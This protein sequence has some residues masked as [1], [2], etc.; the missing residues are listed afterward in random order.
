VTLAAGTRIGSYEILGP[1]GAGG[2]GEVY[3]AIDSELH[4]TVALKVLPEH[5]ITDPDRVA[6]FEREA[7]TLASINHPHVAQ[8]YGIAR[9]DNERAV[10]VMEFVEGEDLAARLRRGRLPLDEALAIG[11]QVA[12]ALEATHEIGVIHRD[13]KPGN[14]RVR[15]DGVVKVLDFGLA[16]TAD[17]RSPSGDVDAPTIS[18]TITEPGFTFGT[19]AYMS[20]EQAKGSTVD[21]RSDLWSFGCVL[22]EMLSGRRA[23]NAT[24][25]V[26]TVAAVLSHGP[27]WDQLP[28]DTSQPIRR[29]LR[30][31]LVRERAQRIDSAAVARLAIE[32]VLSKPGADP[33]PTTPARRGPNMWVVGGLALVTV[34]ILATIAWLPRAPTV[35]SELRLDIATP[36][37]ADAY[38]F[39][40]SPDGRRIAFVSGGSGNPLQLWT[41]TFDSAAATPVPN[42]E[43]A[44]YTFWS[45]DGR[46]IGFFAG[47]KLKRVELSSGIAV[48]LADAAAG[49]GGSW[50]ANGQ[51]LFT[52]SASAPIYLVSA[53]GSAVRPVTSLAPG[54]GGHVSPAWHPDGRRFLYLMRNGDPDKRGSY[55]ATLDRPE[56]A[57]LVDAEGTS[58]FRG[59][60]EILY[61]RDGTLYVQAFDDANNVMTGAARPVASPVPTSDRRSAY[62]ASSSG[63]MAYRKGRM[64]GAQLW[65]FGRNGERLEAFGGPDA[66]GLSGPVLSPTGQRVA[67]IRRPGGNADVWLSDRGGGAATRLTTNPAQEVFPVWM[68]DE[69]A[70]VFRSSRGTTLDIYLARLDTEGTDTLVLSGAALGSVRSHQPTFRVM[71]VGCSFTARLRAPAGTFGPIPLASPA[72]HRENWSAARPTRAAHGFRVMG[73]GSHTRPTNPD[74]SKLQ[75]ENSPLAIGCGRS[76]PAEA[77]IR[78]G[79]GMEGSCSMSPPTAT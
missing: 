56:R 67:V 39:A 7:T 72:R 2:M 36:P 18:L 27:E 6:R 40:L 3:S 34:A 4:R 77:C 45:P 8:I 9:D 14:I 24:T 75:F 53:E 51:I 49:A 20:P 5:F 46:S 48:T 69:R 28:A 60:N 47:G 63:P 37:T 30:Q 33:A 31:C 70:V 13:L 10:L 61:V 35:V 43:G 26:E 41:R 73:D 21:R 22:F 68:P 76:P 55:L 25:V 44:V 29:L 38:S 62:S 17:T 54:D 11:R 12:A 74:G 19:A 65:W 71:A 50:G 16:R 15:S 66:E 59:P 42:T 79:A 23:F 64:D 57:R 32:E 58:E 1:L 52:Q 78:G